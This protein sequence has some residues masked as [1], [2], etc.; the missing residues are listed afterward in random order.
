MNNQPKFNGD[1]LRYKSLMDY[2]A[3]KSLHDLVNNKNAIKAHLRGYNLYASDSSLDDEGTDKALR[4]IMSDD[5]FS[6]LN[7]FGGL[8]IISLCTTY[9]LAVREF[10][11]C[12]F[13]Q[14]PN[15]MYEFLGPDEARGHVSLREVL[16]VG[17]YSDLLL[18]LATKSA[19]VAS[20][21]KYG[22][23]L[24]RMANLCNGDVD[25][26]LTKKLDNIQNI[27][28]KIVHEKYIQTWELDKIQEV[29]KLISVVIEQI[30]LYG[31]NNQI[32]GDYTCINK[33]HVIVVQSVSGLTNKK[34]KHGA[35]TDL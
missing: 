2:V 34:I 1:L 33:E 20:K 32:P 9:E 29:E 12:F 26:E 3:F 7:H 23:A 17:S 16:K 15:H 22:Q 30:C 6:A 19:S 5:V 25:K 8:T 13:M 27:R 11:T 35:A 18:S 31:L 21:G 24:T 10:L 28:N 14:H 4:E